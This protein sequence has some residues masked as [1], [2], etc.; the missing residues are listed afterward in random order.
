MNRLEFIQND[1]SMDTEEIRKIKGLT[2]GQKIIFKE[3]NMKF[4]QDFSIWQPIPE[5]I[6]WEIT[7]ISAQD[8]YFKLTLQSYGYGILGSNDGKAY[9][10]GSIFVTFNFKERPEEAKFIKEI[11]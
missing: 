6:E 7:N 2:K 1:R 3:N 10:N 4:G 9:G 5:D 11:K 8:E